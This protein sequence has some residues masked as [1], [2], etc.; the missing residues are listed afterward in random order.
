MVLI[1]LKLESG[2]KERRK[3][4]NKY[5]WTDEWKSKS[6]R[7]VGEANIHVTGKAQGRKK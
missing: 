6:K 7:R 4:E 3:K 1:I 2:R 5:G